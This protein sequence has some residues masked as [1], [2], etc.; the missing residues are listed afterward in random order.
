MTCNEAMVKELKKL[1]N[2]EAL[3]KVLVILIGGEE[4]LPILNE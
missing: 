2:I 3:L 1:N 4:S